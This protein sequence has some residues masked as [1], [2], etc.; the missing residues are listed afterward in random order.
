MAVHLPQL[1]LSL[2]V[3]VF[4]LGT[5]TLFVLRLIP[6]YRRPISKRRLCLSLMRC[7]F[8]LLLVVLQFKFPHAP[9]EAVLRLVFDFVIRFCTTLT[10]CLEVSN[11]PESFYYY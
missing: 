8:D 9:T 2:S 1:A 3:F 6:Q 4:S 10:V 5:P 11:L 7:M